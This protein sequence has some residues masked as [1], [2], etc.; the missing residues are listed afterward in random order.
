VLE[1]I[2]E[3]ENVG[4][5]GRN[6]DLEGTWKRTRKGQKVTGNGSQKLEGRNGVDLA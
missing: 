3:G 1:V 4:I 5:V 2:P 6:R